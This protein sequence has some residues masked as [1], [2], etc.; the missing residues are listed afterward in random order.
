MATPAQTAQEPKRTSENQYRK[1]SVRQFFC[2][3]QR[4]NTCERKRLHEPAQRLCP[5]QPF[6]YP[7]P[8]EPGTSKPPYN[9]ENS[10][11]K[12]WL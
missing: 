1:I 8:V 3:H 5:S 6:G 2:K 9:T 7:K 11:E 4:S 10:S 12:C